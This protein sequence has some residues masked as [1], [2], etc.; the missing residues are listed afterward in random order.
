MRMQSGHSAPPRTF[1]VFMEATKPLGLS[2]ENKKIFELEI[3][4]RLFF[5]CSKVREA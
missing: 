5:S 2:E 1:F 4:T 3:V